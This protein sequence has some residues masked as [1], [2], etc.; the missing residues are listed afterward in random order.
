MNLDGQGKVAILEMSYQSM[1]QNV[2]EVKLESLC[3]DIKNFQ[4]CL[5][6]TT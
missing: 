3:F 4:S 1:Y 2:T 6:L 5:T